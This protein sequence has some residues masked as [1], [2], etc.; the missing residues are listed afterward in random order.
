MNLK[1]LFKNKFILLNQNLVQLRV[2]WP[3]RS[4]VTPECFYKQPLNWCRWCFACIT[5]RHTQKNVAIY[6]YNKLRRFSILITWRHKFQLILQTKKILLEHSGFCCGYF[7][8]AFCSKF[9]TICHFMTIVY[10]WLICKQLI[11]YLIYAMVIELWL[12]MFKN[13]R[14]RHFPRPRKTQN[15]TKIKLTMITF[16]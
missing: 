13:E 5:P 14:F 11:V 16:V 9:F 2:F 4:F 12:K 10:T 6:W 3:L 8:T 7:Y 1:D 15:E